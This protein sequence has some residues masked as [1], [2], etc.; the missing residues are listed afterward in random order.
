MPSLPCSRSSRLQPLDPSTLVS[1][2][3]APTR[4]VNPA[5]RCLL[6]CINWLHGQCDMIHTGQSYY[7]LARV[8]CIDHILDITTTNVLTEKAND[9]LFVAI[10]SEYNLH[11]STLLV[12]EGHPVYHSRGQPRDALDPT[13][14]A[15]LTNLG[16]A[17]SR[18]SPS[19]D[20]ST[21]DMYRTSEVLMGVR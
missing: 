17:R 6:K 19:A 14:M 7:H 3:A 13:G 12:I 20:W 18:Q 1:R 2:F 8:N 15:C 9:E 21:S 5:I 4:L 10:E 16:S 11:P